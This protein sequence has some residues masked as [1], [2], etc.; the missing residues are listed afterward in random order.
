MPRGGRRE[1]AG[2]PKGS[3]AATAAA[4]M[5]AMAATGAVGLLESLDAVI[6]NPAIDLGIRLEALRRISAMIASRTIMKHVRDQLAL[7]DAPATV[8][9]S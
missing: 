8:G 9:A 7:G 2:K 6:E 5:Q 1:G 3:V 4:L